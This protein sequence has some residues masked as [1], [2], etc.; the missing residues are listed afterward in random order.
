MLLRFSLENHLSINKEQELS[1]IAASLKG[2]GGMLIRTPAIPKEYLLA[3][4]IIYGPNAS[5][6]S[7]FIDGLSLMREAV[8]YSQS[9]WEV[10]SGVHSF[11]FLL[12]AGRN[13]YPSKF[14]VDF[15]SEGVR[16]TYGFVT[17]KDKFIEEWLYSYPEGR[18]RTL[19]TR[20]N[21]SEYKFGSGLTGQ[22]N[23]VKDLVRDNSLFL[24][25]AIQ[26]NFKSLSPVFEFFKSLIF[27]NSIS[28][29]PQAI[30]SEF[31]GKKFDNRVMSFLKSIGTGID[32]YTEIENKRSEEFVRDSREFMDFLYRK[33]DK[34]DEIVKELSEGLD[35]EYKI[36][37]SHK[38]LNGQSVFLDVA[39]ES[40]GTRRLIPLLVSVFDAL[41]NG[42][43][44]IVDEFDASLH[45]QICDLIV[46]LFNNKD[47]NENNAQLIATTHDTNLLCSSNL[48]RDQIWLVE[49]DEYGASELYS[50]AEIK[51]RDTDNFEKGYLQGRYGAIPFSASINNILE[52]LQIDG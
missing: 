19:F 14:E 34:R 42:L 10:G 33:S 22:K 24:S 20:T 41:D 7:N 46:A 18:L 43:I 47:I 4:A 31:K 3:S 23:A 16:F 49:K 2:D 40:T 8:L 5:G 38:T 12:E 21:T 28:S 39:R 44:L 36:E 32:G 26:N 48:R 45:T 50:L 15:V 25:A 29:P 35:K 51:T 6:K 52:K 37:F 27:R 11:P 9:R 13:E 1:M 17:G 30:Y